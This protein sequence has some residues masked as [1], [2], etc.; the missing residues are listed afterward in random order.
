MLIKAG[1][2][3]VLENNIII[4]YQNKNSLTIY[5]NKEGAAKLTIR[6]D[7]EDGKLIGTVNFVV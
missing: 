1:T 2:Y 7:K 5:G 3:K 6:E 4:L